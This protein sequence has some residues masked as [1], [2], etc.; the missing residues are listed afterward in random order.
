M[1]EKV[2]FSVLNVCMDEIV[3]IALYADCH[4]KKPEYSFVAKNILFYDANILRF[5][6]F[7]EQQ[8]KSYISKK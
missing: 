4:G 6:N 3:V 8:L 1:R 2:T 7:G 5:V